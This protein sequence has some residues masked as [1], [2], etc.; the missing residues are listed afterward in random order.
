[1]FKASSDRELFWLF[2]EWKIKCSKK[3]KYECY[4][5]IRKNPKLE[6]IIKNTCAVFYIQNLKVQERKNAKSNAVP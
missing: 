6:K 3:F 4:E 5:V 1:M 2:K